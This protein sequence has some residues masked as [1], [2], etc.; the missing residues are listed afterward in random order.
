MTAPYRRST[1]TA[2]GEARRQDLLERVTEDLAEHGLV[3]FSLRRAARAAGTTHKVLLYYFEG[4]DD[5]LV[6]A[7]DR[8]RARRIDNSLAV[9]AP[10][11]GTFAA[12]V[13]ALWPVL[14]DPRSGHRVLEQSTGL[15]MYDPARYAKFGREATEQYLPALL[16]LCPPTWSG[17][18]RREV[19]EM[20][21][22]TLRGLLLNRVIG[23][24]PASVEAGLA[25]LLRCLE[26]EETA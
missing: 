20:T 23:A 22:A 6:Q 9:A 12:R 1:G 11:E 4:A 25:A 17:Q 19:A 14:I 15:A 21:L 7:V 5:L 10:L 13:R 3:D 24:D 2:R 26:R 16:A 18:R 8:L